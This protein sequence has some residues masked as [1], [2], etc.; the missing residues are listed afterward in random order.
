MLHPST[1]L[2]DKPT[3]V[4]Y[5]ECVLTTKN[6]IRT[7]TVV[8]PDW[9]LELAPEYYDMATYPECEAKRELSRILLKKARKTR[10]TTKSK[11]EDNVKKSG[12]VAHLEKNEK[13][14]TSKDNQVFL[15]CALINFFIN[16]V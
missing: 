12:E 3:W 15:F 2:K 10:K 1:C 8:E 9:L 16:R 14:S 13:Y 11:K 7:C 5:N 4:I 6:Y